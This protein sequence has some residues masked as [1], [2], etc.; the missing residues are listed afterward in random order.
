MSIARLIW[1]SGVGGLRIAAAFALVLLFAFVGS[2]LGAIEG[3]PLLS[4][5]LVLPVIA[6]VV[7]ENFWINGLIPRRS[8]ARL[9]GASGALVS[10]ILALQIPQ[11]GSFATALTILLGFL[12]L[13]AV[14]AVVRPFPV[15]RA[16][17]RVVSE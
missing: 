17:L 4:G 14:A 3:D 15:P 5:W 16:P 11:G 13:F 1:A 2:I 7:F 12:T 8:Y 9:S 6:I 10:V